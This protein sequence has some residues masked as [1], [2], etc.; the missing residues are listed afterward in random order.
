[1]IGWLRGELRERDA[2]RVVLDVSGVGYLLRVPMSTFLDLPPLGSTAELH[3]TTHVREDAITLYGFLTAAERDLFE[4]LNTVSGV[5]PRIALGALSG[6]GP[7][8]LVRAIAEGDPRRLSSVPGIGKKTAERIVIDL[9]DKMS[10]VTAAREPGRAVVG[11]EASDV[12]SALVNLGYQER[13]AARA[14]QDA[15]QDGREGFEALLR[16]ALSRL[17]KA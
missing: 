16:E 6:L 13:L 9:Q 3:V 10:T 15:K 17:G 14:V 8:E 12:V 2:G 7:G 11:G 5:G 4:R 1:M